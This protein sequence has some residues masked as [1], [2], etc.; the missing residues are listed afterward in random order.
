MGS[1]NHNAAFSATSLPGNLPR[2]RAVER[3]NLAVL[4]PEALI[5]VKEAF[6]AKPMQAARGLRSPSFI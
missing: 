5:I 1:V 3:T 2:L 4:D 6:V